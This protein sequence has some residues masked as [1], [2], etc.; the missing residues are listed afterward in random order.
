[1]IR[2]FVGPDPSLALD[3][4]RIG[5]QYMVRRLQIIEAQTFHRLRIVADLSRAGADIGDRNRCTYLHCHSFL[6]EVADSIAIALHPRQMLADTPPGNTMGVTPVE[7]G[8]QAN[9]AGARLLPE[10][11]FP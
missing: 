9:M 2:I 3:R 7:R 5:P 8:G 1:M 10:R 4:R 6:K 11:G